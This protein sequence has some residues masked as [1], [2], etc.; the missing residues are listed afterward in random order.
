MLSQA[1]EQVIL[2]VV[3]MNLEGVLALRW[4][5]RGVGLAPSQYILLQHAANLKGTEF[6]NYVKV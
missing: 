3:E 4:R 2:L 6:S 1:E 5:F